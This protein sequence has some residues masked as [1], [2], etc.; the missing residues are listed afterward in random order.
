VH[1]KRILCFAGF[2]L[3]LVSDGLLLDQGLGLGHMASGCCGK[4]KYAMNSSPGSSHHAHDY[5][6]TNNHATADALTNGYHYTV[7][8]NE[9]CFYCF[10]VLFS[11]LHDAT[12]PR[13]PTFTNQ[14]FPLFVTWKTGKD[15]KLRGCIGTFSPIPLHEGLREY[16]IVSSMKDSRFS[17]VRLDELANLH[18]SVSLLTDFQDC[19]D[20]F[21]WKVGVNGLRIEF[22]NERGHRKTATYLPEVSKEQGWNQRQTVENLLRKGGYQAEIT[23]AFLRT[24]HARRYRTEKVMVSFHDYAIARGLKHKPGSSS[25]SARGHQPYPPPPFHQ[26]GHRNSREKQNGL[27]NHF[28]GRKVHQQQSSRK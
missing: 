14:A 26:Y 5:V 15:L 11:H 9:M 8:S 3:R 24:V 25:N 17:P 4:K 7:A 6:I 1:L 13:D 19:R 18:C 12:P 28:T 27:F 22:N 21:D 20:C 2:S 10:D 23:P 16:A